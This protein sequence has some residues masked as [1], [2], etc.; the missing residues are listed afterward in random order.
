MESL[1]EKYNFTTHSEPWWNEHLSHKL[2]GTIQ[3]S[4]LV[5]NRSLESIQKYSAAVYDIDVKKYS[6]AIITQFPS[7][8]ASLETYFSPFDI[9][10]WVI[11]LFSVFS[12]A[13]LFHLEGI[14]HSK[15][16]KSNTRRT[17]STH[18]FFITLS[19]CLSQVNE[20]F[21]KILHSRGSTISPKIFIGWLFACY[22]LM[23]N[24]YQG[25]IF[26]CLT[27]AIPSRV[28]GTL[29]ELADSSLFSVTTSYHLE[30]RG[31]NQ[32]L[33]YSTLKTAAIPTAI[34][35]WAAEHQFSKLLTKLNQS[36]VFIS[37]QTTFIDRVNFTRDISAFRP[38]S[39]EKN[40]SMLTES[41][42]AIFDLEDDLGEILDCIKIL[43]KRYVVKSR[44]DTRLESG[45][46]SIGRN[47]F[48]ST[49]FHQGLRHLVQ[50]GIKGWW[51]E[52]I[53]FRTRLG[54]ISKP[55]KEY[56]VKY[57]AKNIQKY[58][59]PV[60]FHESQPVSLNV[61]KYI[62]VLC[63][64]VTVVLGG[65]VLIVELHREAEIS[66]ILKKMY[67]HLLFGLNCCKKLVKNW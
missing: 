62:I 48:L 9:P 32:F 41:S 24:V 26:S 6:F 15:I 18:Y 10:T 25:S 2:V 1:G 34:S 60:T 38:L 45:I 3:F 46:L 56:R 28:P 40:D 5:A 31:S 63:F 16:S 44:D 52:I 4:V 43:G 65:I 22:I 21:F 50:S 17:F 33:A 67:L 39:N 57:F 66:V 51:N 59:D 54:I 19:A 35:S 49:H 61:M 37:I 20:N 27:I 53:D 13:L 42:F 8:S 14:V 11:L 30:S 58:R 29:Q 7:N 36:I 23:E 55:G 64:V 47:N 12:V